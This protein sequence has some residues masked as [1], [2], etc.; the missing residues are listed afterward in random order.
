MATA[1]FA[2]GL[3]PLVI[4]GFVARLNETLVGRILRWAEAEMG[5]P[6]TPL[7]LDGVRIRGP[8]GADAPHRPGQRARVGRRHAGG[9]PLLRARSPSGRT[10][11]SCGRVPAL[12]GRLHGHEVARAARGVGG[13]LRRWLDQPTPQALLEASIFF[14]FR[15]AHGAPRR[16][17][18]S[19]R[20]AARPAAPACSSPPWR[21]APSPSGRPAGSCSGSAATSS[22]LDLK[23]KGICPI[24]FLA[25]VYGLE[26]GSAAS[27][28]LA[29]LGAAVDA[30]L[31]EQDTCETLSEAYRFLLRAAPARAAPDGVGGPAPVE[32]VSLA[33]LSSIERSRLRDAFR[34]IEVWQERDGVPLPRTDL[35]WRGGARG[36]IHG[37]RG[38]A[39]PPIGATASGQRRDASTAR[40][41]ALEPVRR[42][43]GSPAA[44]RGDAQRPHCPPREGGRP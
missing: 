32:R 22:K 9:A 25:R 11:T 34:A 33:D 41:A 19:T 24:V 4:G 18:R 26:A 43:N 36:E 35:F 42:A 1:L 5:P 13:A 28:T 21:R 2:G 3:E 38:R 15:A 14:D 6:P 39:E 12:P 40:A 30:G 31:I 27:N 20:V 7:R 29:R 16:L 23:L 44:G 37:L 10:P 8:E 17:A